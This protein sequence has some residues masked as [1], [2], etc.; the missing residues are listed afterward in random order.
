MKCSDFAAFKSNV[1]LR[2]AL[3]SMVFRK[4]TRISTAIRG[5]DTSGRIVNL[6]SSD[7]DTIGSE[8]LY[9]VSSHFSCKRTQKYVDQLRR[10]CAGPATSR[11]Q[12]FS[13]PLFHLSASV[14]G[15]HHLVAAV[16][17]HWHLHARWL[18]HLDRADA[19]DGLHSACRRSLGGQSA[20]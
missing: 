12:S 7:A 5:K 3:C 8:G 19:C 13:R 10:R 17:H 15:R 4:A 18:G 16:R 14:L 2:S 9:Q 20:S 1:T 11:V 6:M